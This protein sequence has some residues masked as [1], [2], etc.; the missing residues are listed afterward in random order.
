MS[1][2]ATHCNTLHGTATHCTALQHTAR[3]CNTLH[4]T[5]THCTARQHTGM[6][7]EPRWRRHTAALGISE[8]I[9]RTDCMYNDTTGISPTKQNSK[10]VTP[11]R[12]ISQKPR[13][14]TKTRKQINPRGRKQP[15]GMHQLLSHGRKSNF[16]SKEIK[17]LGITQAPVRIF[18]AQ[19]AFRVAPTSTCAKPRHSMGHT[20]RI[21][22]LERQTARDMRRACHVAGREMAVTATDVASMSIHMSIHF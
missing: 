3:R 17:F 15:G 6:T 18:F 9:T 16:L 11:L 20:L 21:C 5:A 1:V 22:A 10:T 13:G 19:S 12:L 8:S 14:K 7:E 2:A 4:G